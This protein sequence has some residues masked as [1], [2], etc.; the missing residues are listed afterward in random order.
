MNY[1]SDGSNYGRQSAL[2]G[3]QS[4]QSCAGPQELTEEEAEAIAAYES[5]FMTE[6]GMN[7][8]V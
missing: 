6:R 1:D 2:G 8:T 7:H 4:V 5:Y 3:R